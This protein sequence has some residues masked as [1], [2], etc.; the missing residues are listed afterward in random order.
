MDPRPD[1]IKGM[2]RQIPEDACVLTYN[3]SFE[4]TR[5]KELIE[6]FPENAVSISRIHDNVRDLI[7]PFRKRYAYRW[8]QRG[9]NSIK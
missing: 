1:L 4:K 3:M 9:S 8:Q 2:L 7:I 6:A 5:L